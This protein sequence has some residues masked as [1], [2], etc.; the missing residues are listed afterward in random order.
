MQQEWISGHAQSADRRLLHRWAGE[1]GLAP[2]VTFETEDVHSMLEMIRAGLAVG[3]IPAT[4]LSGDEVGIKRVVLPP[5]VPPL[6]R[7]IFAVSR[8][9]VRPEVI[10]ELVTLLTQTLRSSLAPDGLERP[11]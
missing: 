3:L 10:N 5:G 11:T 7:Q 4:L 9:S 2:H 6:N 1:L 8:T